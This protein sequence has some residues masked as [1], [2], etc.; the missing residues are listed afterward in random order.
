MNRALRWRLLGLGLAVAALLGLVVAWSASP[1]RA[2]LDVAR[3][4]AALQGV[5]QSL[6]PVAAVAGFALASTLAVPLGFLTVVTLVAYGPWAGTGCT[7]LGGLLGAAA[8]YGLGRLLGRGVLQQVGGA[9]VN[10]I[11]ARLGAQGLWAVLFVRIVPVAPFAIVNM[12]AGASQ[13]RLRDMLL[14]TAIGMAPGTLVMAFFIDQ[15]I[16]AL[17]QP[18]PWT[19]A[20][21]GVVLALLAAGGWALRRWL[22]RQSRES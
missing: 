14:G 5:G 10:Q 11:S 6:G 8:S 22:G 9:R 20:I 21:G 12:V 15:I 4:V 2:W 13:I 16:A 17:R 19:F 1:L 3:I 7:L 18:G